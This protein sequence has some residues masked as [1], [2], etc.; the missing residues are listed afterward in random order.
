MYK[1]FECL[2]HVSTINFVFVFNAVTRYHRSVFYFFAI[3]GA[4]RVNLNLKTAAEEGI[5]KVKAA[6]AAA[7]FVTI[8]MD[9]WKKKGYTSSYLGISASFY[10]QV[11]K[12]AMHVILNLHTVQHPHTGEMIAECLQQTL[13]EWKIEKRRILMIITDNGSNMIKGV[14]QLVDREPRETINEAA[15]AV[16][17][18]NVVDDVGVESDDDQSSDLQLSSDDMDTT[19]IPFKYKLLSCLAHTV[20]L[21]V[22]TLDKVPAYSNAIAKARGVVSSIRMSSVATQKLLAL[23]CKGVI[24]D[25]PTRWSSSYL[26]INRL[27]EL[28]ESITSVFQAMCWDCLVQSEWAKLDEISCLLRPFAG[29][30][31]NLQTDVMALSNVIPVIQDLQCHLDDPSVNRVMANKLQLAMAS[32][33]Q[34]YTD[35]LDSEFDPLP[36]AACLLSPDVAATLLTPEME[37]LLIAVKKYIIVLVSFSP[38]CFD[39]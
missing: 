22:K 23:S 13:D 26:L 18:L 2:N 32:R 37:N 36:A 24:A 28:K 1:R 8:G 35:P 7:R 10:N 39:F 6:L 30:T 25:C 16:D 20:Q 17:D 38:I 27:L 9:I 4:K 29:H 3:A 34:K 14:K 15:E 5:T 31:N 21:I 11:L 12:R 19:S 33:F